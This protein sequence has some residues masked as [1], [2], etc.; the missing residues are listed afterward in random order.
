MRSYNG[1][2]QVENQT[3]LWQVNTRILQVEIMFNL[4]YYFGLRVRETLPQLTENSSLRTLNVWKKYLRIG[5][6]LLSKSS[7]ASQNQNLRGYEWLSVTAC[8][9]YCAI[10][11][12]GNILFPKP[13]RNGSQTILY[14]TKQ[15]VGKNTTD[16]LITRLSRRYTNHCIRVTAITLG[17]LENGFSNTDICFFTAWT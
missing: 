12:K 6:E 5:H 10:I 11:R 9:Q 15:A 13:S 1:Y 8:L 2:L 3:I 7:R 14:T 4:I 17:L 16:S